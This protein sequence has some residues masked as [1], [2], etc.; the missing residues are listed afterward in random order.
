MAER[1]QSLVEGSAGF[2]DRFMRL[3]E[4]FAI[5]LVQPHREQ[6]YRHGERQTGTHELRGWYSKP[7]GAISARLSSPARPARAGVDDAPGGTLP[8]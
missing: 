2:D 7:Q 8:A 6:S 4:G 3:R 1:Y 5:M